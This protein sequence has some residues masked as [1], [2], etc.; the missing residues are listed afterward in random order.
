MILPEE[1]VIE[2]LESPTN[3][4]N[5]L[6]SAFNPHKKSNI[7]SIPSP[8]AKDIIPDLDEKISIGTTKFKAMS[9]MNSAMDELKNRLPEIQK[10]EKLAAIA[11]EMGKIVVSQNQQAINDNRIG[12]I[13]VY[14]PRIVSEENF[15]VVDMKGIE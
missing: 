5:R 6:R 14:S 15:E 9:I 4:M 10:P 13:I 2:R 1:E 8:T 11:Y 3:L 12:Q 7:P